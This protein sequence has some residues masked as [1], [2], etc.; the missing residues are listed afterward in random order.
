[1]L[2]LGIVLGGVWLERERLRL[3]GPLQGD[4]SRELLPRLERWARERP[5]GTAG[6]AVFGDSRNDCRQGVTVGTAL[7]AELRRHE[8]AVAV[9]DVAH[10]MFRS[11]QFY[12]LLGDVL[13]GRPAIAVIEVNAAFVWPNPPPPA[14]CR[15]HN[16]SRADTRQ[17]WRRPH[18][19]R[20]RS[21]APRSFVYRLE[22]R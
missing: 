13:A 10:P 19:R 17:A 4:V 2:T 7:E 14:G 20:R 6:A 5:P 12:Y 3:P 15:F 8:R 18:R 22:R 1:V 16:L 9:V 21:H 11:L